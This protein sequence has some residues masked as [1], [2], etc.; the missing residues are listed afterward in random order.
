MSVR[1]CNVVASGIVCDVYVTVHAARFIDV[2]FTYVYDSDMVVSAGQ[3]RKF[4]VW[5]RIVR[6]KTRESNPTA[7]PACTDLT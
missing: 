2:V 5:V 6:D 3:D 4:K 7:T 1:V